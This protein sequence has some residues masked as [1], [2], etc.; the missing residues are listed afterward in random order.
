MS[1]GLKANSDGSAAI[2]V[3]GTD[4]IGLGSTGNINFPVSGQRITGDF[5][6]ATQSNIVSFQTSTANAATSVSAIPSGT[7]NIAAFTAL[8]SSSPNNA[9]YAQ[10]LVTNAIVGVVS[11]K[12][13]TGTYLPLVF[14]AGGSE[15]MRI[16]TSRNVG[17]GT[18]GSSPDR[19]T[20]AG[21]G[22]TGAP[23]DGGSKTASIRVTSSSGN[24]NDGGQIE[25]GAGFG[26]Y[27]QSYFSA[28]KG[29]LSNSVGNTLGSL[30]FY[31]R[32]ATGDTSLT[33]RARITSG[34]S[35]L[36]N[37][38]TELIN[39]PLAVNGRASIGDGS[40]Y[41]PDTAWSGQLTIN[42]NGYSAGLAADA[43]G[44]WVGT[45]SASRAVIFAT[46]ETE[47]ARF[48]G[49]GALVFAGG[50]TNANGIGITFPAT[51]SASSN[52]NTLD[53]Y[54]EGTWT[55]AIRGSGTAGTY[56]LALAN[57]FYTKIG[58]S[59]TIV[60]DVQFA[61]SITGGGTGYLQITGIPF[62]NA[63]SI[64]SQGA[65]RSEGLDMSTNYTWLTAM[66]ITSPTTTWYLPE[67][68]DNQPGADFAIS[69]VSAN[70]AIKF[71]ATFFTT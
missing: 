46:D 52:A 15:A 47:R 7:N 70:D 48:N 37:T 31:T 67:S 9:S 34:G 62:S 55:P 42:G 2:Q 27:S 18:L 23:A 25:F 44:L 11:E 58:R 43:S 50:T 69:G 40:N 45:N 12:L 22:E 13:G 56:Q 26:T 51:Q 53:D 49:T 8:N 14:G 60:C 38:Q 33:E 39:F 5:S 59:V 16:D 29:L 21:A 1:T 64:G 6:N 35:L 54:E 63:S 24:S 30:A 3:G 20:V 36:I 41:S 57:G 66:P 65:V 68:G 4:V 32:N 28:I 17:I 61:G 19:L 10:L 71:T